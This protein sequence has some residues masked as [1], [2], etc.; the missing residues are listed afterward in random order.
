MIKNL[1]TY[2]D[3]FTCAVTAVHITD[4]AVRLVVMKKKGAGGAVL[5]CLY[6]KRDEEKD[7]ADDLKELFIKYPVK[8][9]VVIITDEVRFLASELNI[10]D[11]GLL[12]EEKQLAAARWEIEPYLD[13]TPAE[14]L[15]ACEIMPRSAQ[16]RAPALV[17][18]IKRDIY[19]R[20][21]AVLKELRLKLANICA[22]E[23]AIALSVDHK[24][25]KDKKF[26]IGCYDSRI[27]GV[28]ITDQGPIVFQEKSPVK[29]SPGVSVNQILGELTDVAGEADEVVLAGRYILDEI[30]GIDEFSH[31][32]IRMWNYD[33]LKRFVVEGGG[34]IGPEYAAAVGA[35]LHELGISGIRMPVLTDRVPYKKIVLKKINEN[36]RLIPGITLGMLVVLF[37]AHYAWTLASTG[38]YE[39][40]FNRLKMEERTLR[41]P[42]EEEQGLRTEL[43]RI[44]E[45]ETYIKETLPQYNIRILRMLDAVSGLIPGDVALTII[46]QEDDGGF[47]IEGNSLSGQSITDF[48]D[49]LQSLDYCEATVVENVSSLKKATGAREKI[50]PYSFS[51]KMRFASWHSG[52]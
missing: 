35:A 18:A 4:D 43:D 39:K 38:I 10:A 36:P 11:A 23:T 30:S 46:R 7:P 47:T 25:G 9:K 20:Y 13:F 26:I 19:N 3:R 42:V 24:A 2:F 45:K 8:G 48:N 6:L 1:L 27:I 51:I 29:D 21:E 49:A 37:S 41:M 31:T 5:R 14:G 15:F 12:P 22:P 34:E 52:R 17:T 40:R 44:R 28:C 16:G 33:D 32:P 50:L